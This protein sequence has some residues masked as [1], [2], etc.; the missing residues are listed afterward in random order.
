MADFS[1]IS[2]SKNLEDRTDDTAAQKFLTA[3]LIKLNPVYAVRHIKSELI[4]RGDIVP[5]A[6][7]PLRKEK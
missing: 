7:S 1:K 6:Q 4:A 3:L 5:P 2:E